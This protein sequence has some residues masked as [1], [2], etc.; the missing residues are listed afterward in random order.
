MKK[1]GFHTFFLGLREY[2]ER[3]T[4]VHVDGSKRSIEV[5]DPSIRMM[6]RKRLRT[7]ERLESA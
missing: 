7:L 6:R 2:Y 1:L 5:T 3:R 4:G